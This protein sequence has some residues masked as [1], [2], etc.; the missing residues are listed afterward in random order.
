MSAQR[1]IEIAKFDV[2]DDTWVQT[3]GLWTRCVFIGKKN[4]PDSPVGIA[5]KAGRDV[6]DLVAGKRAFS[7]TTMTVVLS[8][9]VMHDGKWMSQGDIYVSP[10]NDMSGDLLFGPEGAVIFMMF[11]K[12]SGLAPKF[13]NKNDQANFD[14]LLRK[15]VDEVASGKIEK[16]V[17]ILPLRDKYTEGRAIVYN[18]VEEVAKYRAE[19]GTDW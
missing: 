13:A 3:G 5:I 18:T 4:N 6:G 10:P 11:D 8:G 17:A 9:T 12:R 19:T 15:D 16:S 7:T 2:L 1:A 14:K